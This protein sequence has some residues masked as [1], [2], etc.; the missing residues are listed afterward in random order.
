MKLE[1]EKRDHAELIQMVIAIGSHRSP[2]E[3]EIEKRNNAELFLMVITIGVGA[4]KRPQQKKDNAELIQS[5]ITI[6]I[7]WSWRLS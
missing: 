4:P 2:L 7:H 6:E 5:M 1:I 3:L